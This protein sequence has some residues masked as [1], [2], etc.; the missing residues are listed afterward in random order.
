MLYAT[1]WRDLRWRLLAA[2]ALVAP[3]AMLVAWSYTLKEEPPYVRAPT[4]LGFLDQVWFQLPGGSAVFLLL[5]VI[6][7]AGGGL[8]RPRNDLAYLLT[9]PVTRRRWLFAHI[10]ASLAALA[11]LVLLVAVVLLAGAWR[12]GMP[13]P[14]GPLLARSFGV[15]VAA[16]VW[17]TVM[18]AVLTLVRHPA[19]AIVAVLGVVV[20]MPTGRFRLELPARAT[21]AL[22]PA[23]DPWTLADPRAWSDGVPFAS[24]LTACALGAAATLLA[25]YRLERFEP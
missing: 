13:L 15:F 9:L 5:A 1:I 4:Y 11:A 20:A 7:S 6:V 18:A 8:L 22:L 12:A 21:T 25:L 16:G 14:L 10:G 24:M 17:V 3:L 19:L 2:L 23:W